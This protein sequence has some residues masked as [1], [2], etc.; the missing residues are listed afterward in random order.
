MDMDHLV[1][2]L[3]AKLDHEDGVLHGM[4]LES[5]RPATT[6]PRARVVLDPD[7]V[8]ALAAKIY[9]AATPDMPAAYLKQIPQ[10]LTSVYTERVHGRISRYLFQ[11]FAGGTNVFLQGAAVGVGAS[12]MVTDAA[13]LF[14]QRCRQHGD[15][16]RVVYVRLNHGIATEK[17]LLESLC[18]AVQAPLTLWERRLRSTTSIGLRIMHAAQRLGVTSFI[19]DHVQNASSRAR[20][21]IGDLMLHCDSRYHV[22]L[23]V[24]D[25]MPAGRIGVVLVSHW[26]PEDLFRDSEDALVLLKGRMVE[27][28]P[29]K[30]GEELAEAIRLAGVGLEDLDLRY[31]EDLSF[32]EKLHEV[33]DGLAVNVFGLLQQVGWLATTA[34]GIRPDEGILKSA[35]GLHHKMIQLIHAKGQSGRAF[36]RTMPM[37]SERPGL[38]KIPDSNAK[39]PK[40][41]STSKRENKLKERALQQ[42]DARKEARD[43]Q[44][45]RSVN[46]PPEVL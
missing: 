14:N 17:D 18:S 39:R 9:A 10:D 5:R 30:K 27:L 34:G 21:I 22:P 36:Y 45:H 4:A 11:C 15:D 29:Y 16:R 6:E 2:H 24:E 46:L 44:R 43:I 13:R 28:A 38:T 41:G 19:F 20:T 33:T 26:D 42:E 23:Q 37:Q 25:E 1:Q 35:I 40:R 31:P 8:D 3:P 12:T 7:A 32:T